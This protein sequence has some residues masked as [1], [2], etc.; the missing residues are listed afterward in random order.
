M[1]NCWQTVRLYLSMLVLLLVPACSNSWGSYELSLFLVLR[2]GTPESYESHAA[3]LARII[4]EAE[5]S[6][7]KPPPGICT[8]CGYYLAIL[9]KYH[10]WQA[11]LAKEVTYYPESQTFVTVLQ[12]LLEGDKHVIT[13]KNKA[14][15][16]SN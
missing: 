10:G 7:A 11:Y 1:L 6:G 13:A 4:E 8:E 2:E 9:Q 12:R 14:P 5:Y 3:L 15:A 16:K